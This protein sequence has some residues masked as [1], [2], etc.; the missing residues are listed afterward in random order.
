MQQNSPAKIN[1]FLEV[2]GHRADGYHEIRTVFAPLHSPL[3]HISLARCT[4]DGPTL[5]CDHVEVPVD[6]RN[7]CW[8]ALLLHARETGLDS[9]WHID[10]AKRIPVAAGLGG[11]S[12]DAAATLKLLNSQAGARA[13]SPAALSRLASQLGADVPFFLEPTVSLAEGIGD[14]L[15][16]V[17]C[18]ASLPVLLV[19]PGCPISAAWAYGAL[20]RVPV[21]DPPPVQALLDALAAGDAA[22]VAA[23]TF[24]ALE[25]AVLHKFPLLGML[26]DE[27]VT[28]GCM[29]VHISGSGPT[30]FALGESDC[31]DD[32][33]QQMEQ[34][35]GAPLWVHRTRI[36]R[37]AG[38]LSQP[39]DS[40]ADGN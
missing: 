11:G 7:L 37:T 18:A 36:M 1:L 8:N 5:A 22:G 40:A 39:H 19:N 2:T 14:K 17:P 27:L 3:D 13:L 33:A 21:P 15:Q 12:S 4:S 30:L 35:V 16:P 23:N 31:L 6:E 25:H 34:R 29:A 38:L 10:L 9:N 20:G 28:A 24:N 26:R 32:A